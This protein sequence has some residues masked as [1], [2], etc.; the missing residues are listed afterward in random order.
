MI[1]LVMGMHK[2]GTTLLA[3]LVH[4]A[5]INLGHDLRVSDRGYAAEKAESPAARAINQRLIGENGEESL[6]APVPS[7]PV[8]DGVARSAMQ[9]FLAAQRHAY[10]D[11]GMKDPR[12]LLTYPCWRERLGPHRILAI[13]RHPK[14]VVR[15]Y[16]RPPA[17]TWQP[18]RSL[19]NLYRQAF[20]LRAWK[21]YNGRLAQLVRGGGVPVLLLSYEQLMQDDS[22]LHRIAA[23]LGREVVDLRESRAKVPAKQVNA[24]F[25]GLWARIFRV[26]RTYAELET[27]RSQAPFRPEPA[28]GQQRY[29]Y[30]GEHG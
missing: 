14:A 24:F 25:Y 5:G 1:Y 8:P 10:P 6:Y 27:L 15:H 12:L 30:D 11:W 17:G 16:M 23:F 18:L 13:Y 29:R 19:R 9:A 20:A 7:L 22:Q 2:S 28:H 26:G 4:S 21:R 3:R